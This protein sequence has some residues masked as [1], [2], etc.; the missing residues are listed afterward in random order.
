MP[1]GVIE[2]RIWRMEK[3]IQL[4]GGT[5]TLFG[6]VEG[7]RYDG[8]NLALVSILILFRIEAM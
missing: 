5:V 7:I 6:N 2:T 1:D 8:S 3:D 4:I